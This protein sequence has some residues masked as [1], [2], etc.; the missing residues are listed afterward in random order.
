MFYLASALIDLGLPHISIIL[1]SRLIGHVAHDVQKTIL[2]SMLDNDESPT[3][4]K[5]NGN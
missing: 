1:F 4:L 3:V 5:I 2:L